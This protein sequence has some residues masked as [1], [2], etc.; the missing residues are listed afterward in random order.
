MCT[1]VRDI[2]NP[3]NIINSWL[4]YTVKKT[5]YGTAALRQVVVT[6]RVLLG[7]RTLLPEVDI[8]NLSNPLMY[9]VCGVLP[10]IIL[11]RFRCVL[12]TLAPAEEGRWGGGAATLPS[13]T[14]S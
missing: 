11:L 5:H 1:H 9:T 2:T 10:S 3:P 14:A 12:C 7:C 4:D 8:S 6:T 13:C